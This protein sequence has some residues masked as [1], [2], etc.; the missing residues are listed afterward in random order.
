MCGLSQHHSQSSI[1][2]AGSFQARQKYGIKCHALT[3]DE[4]AREESMW[5]CCEK[6]GLSMQLAL[7]R[8][9]VENF[10]CDGLV[11]FDARVIV[12]IGCH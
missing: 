8:T 1:I 2:I 12:H 11:D 4:A 5:P 7:S 10:A 9:V 3:Q 6:R